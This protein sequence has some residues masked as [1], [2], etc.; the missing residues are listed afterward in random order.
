MPE[1]IAEDYQSQTENQE[2]DRG[3]RSRK[4]AILLVTLP[5]EQGRKILEILDEEMVE[6]VS[7]EIARLDDVSPEERNEVLEEFYHTALAKEYVDEGGI[8]YAKTLLQDFMPRDEVNEILDSVTKS[9]EKDPFDFLQNAETENVVTFLKDEHPQT[10]AMVLAWL[11]KTKSAEVLAALSREK[12]VDC[13]ERMAKMEHTSPEII[14]RVEE[15]LAEKLSNVVGEEL[16]KSGGVEA[17]AEILNN[18]GRSTEKNILQTIEEDD[19]D[20]V[21]EIRDLMFVFEDIVLVNDKGVQE[22]L[23][24]VDT[25]ELALALKTAS[26]ELKEKFFRNL[27]ERAVNMIQEEL[28]YMGPVRLSEVE[29]AQQQIIDTIQALEE[30]GRAI[31]E[32]RGGAEEEVIV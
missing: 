17:V 12:Q 2:P 5:K 11:G 14:D 31:I 26:E 25:E 19:P 4:A 15:A 9:L 1:S 10:I 13:V 21:D 6:K 7:Y 30:E 23:K 32:G 16:H 18:T 20:L 28:E 29:A 3:S 8:K 27:S 22:A 24:E